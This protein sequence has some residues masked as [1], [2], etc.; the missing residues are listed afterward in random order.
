MNL[1]LLAQLGLIVVQQLK[2][3]KY[4]PTCNLYQRDKNTFK[5]SIFKLKSTSTNVDN[6]DSVYFR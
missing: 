1:L 3:N 2:W 6:D 5:Q 4:G